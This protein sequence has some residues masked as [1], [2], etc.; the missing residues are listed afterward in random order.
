MR[1]EDLESGLRG[2]Y[3]FSGDQRAGVT[4][5]RRWRVRDEAVDLLPWE[6]GHPDLWTE[7]VEGRAG[8]ETAGTSAPWRSRWG[9]TGLET[10]REGSMTTSASERSWNFAEGQGAGGGVQ[11]ISIKIGCLC[12]LGSKWHLLGYAPRRGS[13]AWPFAEGP[14]AEGPTAAAPGPAGCPGL[15]PT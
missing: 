1:A 2:I 7:A 9:R 15:P 8:R 14:L 13:P 3:A 11:E 12:L 4:R 10:G 5:G 6:G